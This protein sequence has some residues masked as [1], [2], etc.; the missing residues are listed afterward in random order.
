LRLSSF[1]GLLDKTGAANLFD[2]AGVPEL[3]IGE[4]FGT[5]IVESSARSL[6]PP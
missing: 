4:L 2:P 5:R 1:I 3:F 6:S